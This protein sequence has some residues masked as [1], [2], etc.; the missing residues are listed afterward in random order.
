MDTKGHDYTVVR[1]D[2]DSDG[3]WHSLSTAD[4][5]DPKE[6][7]ISQETGDVA[8]E[9]KKTGSIISLNSVCKEYREASLDELTRYLLM[10]LNTTGPVE[11]RELKIDGVKALESTVNANMVARGSRRPSQSTHVRVRAAVMSKDGCTYD[12]MMIAQPST[13]NEIAPTFERFL[14]GFR[15][16]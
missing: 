9:H 14:K 5:A 4:D 8:F 12:F 1:L 7:T 11:T 10:G 13:F 15:A 3:Q 16:N 2:R 6:N